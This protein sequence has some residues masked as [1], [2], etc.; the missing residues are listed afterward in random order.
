MP[1][2]GSYWGGDGPRIEID[3][4]LTSFRGGKHWSVQILELGS[5]LITW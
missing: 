3:M 1:K 4:V 5:Q 2:W